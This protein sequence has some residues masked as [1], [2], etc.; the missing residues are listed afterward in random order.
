VQEN[1]VPDKESFIFKLA[2]RT[3]GRNKKWSF[4]AGTIYKKKVSSKINAPFTAL[5]INI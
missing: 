5:R 1:K 4:L 2:G 3:G